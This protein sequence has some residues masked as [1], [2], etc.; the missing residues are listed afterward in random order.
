MALSLSLWQTT[1]NSYSHWQKIN[2]FILF[3]NGFSL[4]LH[5]TN[6]YKD[7]TTYKKQ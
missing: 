7:E 6:L 5:E 4:T 3:S 1:G 2:H